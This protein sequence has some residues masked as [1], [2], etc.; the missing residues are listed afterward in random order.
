MKGLRSLV[1][2]S[3][4][5]TQSQFIALHFNFSKGKNSEMPVY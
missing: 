4:Y 5:Q 1:I 2:D 3:T